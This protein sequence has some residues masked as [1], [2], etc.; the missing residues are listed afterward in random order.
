VGVVG[1]ER[2][3]RLLQGGVGWGGRWGKE[4]TPLLPPPHPPPH[5]FT[6]NLPSPIFAS[7]ARPH[8]L[9]CGWVWRV[10]RRGCHLAWESERMR[11]AGVISSTLR[12]HQHGRSRRAPYLLCPLQGRGGEGGGGAMWQS[13]RG[14]GGFV[15]THKSMLSRVCAPVYVRARTHTH[16]QP[17][18][19]GGAAAVSRR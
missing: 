4:N 7:T 8:V 11:A 14:L 6:H 13:A 9:S 10:V 16:T 12:S 17:K 19:G 2:R 15:Y 3:I 18:T 1:G 5:T